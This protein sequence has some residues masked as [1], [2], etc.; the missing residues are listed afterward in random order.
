MART[1]RAPISTSRKVEQNEKITEWLGTPKGAWTA[2]SMLAAKTF[3]TFA[4]AIK[5]LIP[6]FFAPG[7]PGPG[8]MAVDKYYRCYISEEFV[9]S[10]V[11]LAKSVTKDAPCQTCGAD[12]HHPLSYVAG[13]ICHEAQHPPRA[14]NNRAESCMAEPKLWNVAADMEINDDL[15]QCFR[16]E[17][18]HL[19]HSGVGAA[20]LCLPVSVVLPATFRTPEYAKHGIEF[21]DNLTAEMYYYKL[22]DLRRKMEEAGELPSPGQPSQGEGEGEGEESDGQGKPTPGQGNGN[23]LDNN[24]QDCGSGAH[25]DKQ[26]WESD[27]PGPDSP[28]ISEA[29]GRAIQKDIAKEIK[30]AQATRGDQPGGMQIWA[31]GILAPA[32]VNWRTHFKSLVRRAV[33]FK[34]GDDVT[35]Y[36]RLGR[37]TAASGYSQPFPS[38]HTP[39]P[40][41]GVVLDTSGSMGYGEGSPLRAAWSEVEG[42]CKQVQAQVSFM[43]VDA[44]AGTLQEI[45]S[46]KQA[47]L[48]GGGGTDMRVGIAAMDKAK[49]PVTVCIVLTDGYTPWPTVAPRHMKVIAALVGGGGAARDVPSFITTVVVDD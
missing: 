41:I 10:M 17:Y 44:V 12:Q 19:S 39:V 26:G 6:K 37:A 20:K 33:A 3:W 7:E 16:M 5:S 4:P 38:T 35:T 34:R 48:Q 15:L 1:R 11:A 32:K 46:F 14:H 47:T 27:T 9:T 22:L 23:P 18:E 25:G 28:G 30:R 42:I 24:G 40:R 45:T 21:P 8:T 49:N 13:V 43:S 31:E 36:R 2:A 29:E